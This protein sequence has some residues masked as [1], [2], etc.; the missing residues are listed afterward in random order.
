M[1]V[2][3]RLPRCI[4]YNCNMSQSTTLVLVCLVVS[5]ATLGTGNTAGNRRLL[6]EGDVSAALEEASQGVGSFID[7]FWGGDCGSEDMCVDYIAT[8][9]PSNECRPSW[10]VWMILIFIVLSFLASCICCI[11]CGI[12]TCLMDCLCCR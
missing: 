7:R 12:C 9:G 8:C 11:C 6:E 3:V 10:W 1:G 4:H 2:K 5:L